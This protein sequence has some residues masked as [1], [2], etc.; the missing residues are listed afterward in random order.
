MV[1]WAM[2]GMDDEWKNL[3][4][5]DGRLMSFLPLPLCSRKR[6]NDAKLKPNDKRNLIAF[7][8]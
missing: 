2:N 8:K 7:A 4:F 5:L 1:K 6:I 3:T